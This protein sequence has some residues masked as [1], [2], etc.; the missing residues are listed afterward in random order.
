MRRKNLK[1]R[2]IY[3]ETS[4]QERI[5][6]HIIL[7]TLISFSVNVWWTHL[8][9]LQQ[10]LIN[11]SQHGATIVFIYIIFDCSWFNV[12]CDQ[13]KEVQ[14]NLFNVHDQRAFMQVLYETFS[15]INNHICI[16]YRILLRHPLHQS[17]FKKKLYKFV[18]IFKWNSSKN[19][20]IYVTEKVAL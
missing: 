10:R 12:P 7:L 8:N 14:C 15:S 4:K 11:A 20:E 13:F 17:Q 19:K 1:H 6:L 18:I 3:E 9:M 5:S 2:E 16:S